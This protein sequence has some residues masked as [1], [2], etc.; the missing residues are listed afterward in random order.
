MLAKPV[1]CILTNERLIHH[2]EVTFKNAFH[3]KKTKFGLKV[4]AFLKSRTSS[5]TRVLNEKGDI[6]GRHLRISTFFVCLIVKLNYFDWLT[7]A[8]PCLDCFYAIIIV[9]KFNKFCRSCEIFY[10][11]TGRILSQYFVC[12]N[13]C[14]VTVFALNQFSKMLIV[15]QGNEWTLCNNNSHLSQIIRMMPSPI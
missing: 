9:W 11:Q 5:S 8:V 2:N 10:V 1:R 14:G 7:Q 12:S 15:N 3:L 4:K 6:R 13:I